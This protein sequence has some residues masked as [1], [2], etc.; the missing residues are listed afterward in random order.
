MHKE[1]H[2]M[3]TVSAITRR[4]SIRKYTNQPVSDTDLKD[5]LEA[6]VMAPSA[7]NLQ[8]WYF[9]VIRSP[10]KMEA[11]KKLM[12]EATKNLMP[13]W[14]RRFAKYPQFITE[15][16][17]FVRFLGDAPVCILAF[18]LQTEYEMPIPA[19]QSVAAAIENM[20]L[21][22]TDKG[23]GSCW[24]TAPLAG[25]FGQEVHDMFAPDKG[26]LVAMITLGYAAQS[27]SMPRRKDGRYTII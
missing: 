21:T 27:P 4:R 13:Y 2:H 20:L 14:H 17:D 10:E 8:P 18:L 9:I 23:L 5:I 11:L 25:G 26:E 24:L 22:A 19:I 12:A 6:A 1:V 16:A 3:E 7:S 15:T